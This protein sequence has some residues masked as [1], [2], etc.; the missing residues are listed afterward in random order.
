MTRR[1]ITHTR[2]ERLDGILEC[3]MADESASAQSLAAHFD[4]SLMTV[5]RDLDELQRRGIVRKFRGGVSIERTSSYEIAAALRRRIALPQKLA[6][7]AV[8]ASGVSPGQVVMLDDS[9][10]ASQ[11]IQYLIDIEELRV[12]TNYLPSLHELSSV[13][14]I[15]VTAIGGDFDSGHESFVGEGAA[16]AVREL[17]VDALYFSTSSADH[18]GIYHQEEKVVR[19]KSE[20]IRCAG[21]RILLMDSSKLGQTSL[22]RVGGWDVINE[23]ITD[24]G[25]AV[26]VLESIRAQGVVVR[27]VPSIDYVDTHEERKS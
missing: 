10:T 25:A 5:H 12:V 4:I 8:A 26:E 17:R 6:I 3:L 27:T 19:L 23:L 13:T 2:Q 20:M 21:R 15:S 14:G 24:D 9:T 7:G 16:K 22:H 18:D 11:M 1:L